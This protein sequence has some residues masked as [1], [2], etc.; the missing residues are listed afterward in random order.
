MHT[1]LSE[2]QSSKRMRER[3]SSLVE[4]EVEEFCFMYIMGENYA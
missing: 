4:Y 1:T 2:S 3:A